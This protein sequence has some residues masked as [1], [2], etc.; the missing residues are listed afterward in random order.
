VEDD[1]KTRHLVPLA[2]LLL[3]AG[4]AKKDWPMYRQNVPRNGSQRHSS[5]LSN[6]S[7]VPSLAVR[8]TFTVPAAD[9]V[10]GMNP[11]FRA[12]PVVHKNRVYIGSGNGRMY[13][14]DAETGAVL[15][16]FPA[17]PAAPLRSQFTCNPSSQGIASSAVVAEIGE[18]DAVIFGAPD[19]SVGTNLGEGRLFALNAATGAEIWRSQVVAQLTGTTSGSTT[20]LHQQ[21]GYSSPIVYDR[22][23]YVGVADHCDNPIQKG[24]IVSVRLSDGTFDPA[25]TYCSTGTCGDSTRGGGVWSGV[26]AK[27][28]RLYATTGNANNGGLEPS[29][30]HGLSMVQLNAGTGAMGWKFQPVPYA[31]DWDPDWSAGPNVMSTSCGLLSASTMKDGWTH[32]VAAS[33]GVRRWTFPPATIPFSSGDGT[34]HGD[35]RFMRAGAAWG[36]VFITMTGG[37]TVSTNLFSAYRR[38]HALNVCASDAD[39]IRWIIDVPNASGGTYSLGVPTVTRGIVYIGTDQGHLVAIA[40]PSVQP[41][42]GMRCSNTDVTN[43]ACVAS[44]YSLVP[45]PAVLANVTLAG[46]M[47]YN[48]AAISKGRLFAATGAGNVYMLRP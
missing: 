40:D 4:C 12:S 44:G 25:F 21:I 33:T 17:P 30:N 37:L 16:K 15:W 48:E 36:D 47:V 13:A 27:A 9:T 39:R 5:D 29:P 1:M 41:A 34:V 6:P 26:A 46:S 19:P 11:G 20:Q 14:L 32:A 2:G 31:L 24:R 7:R 38:L 23:V 28:D 45:Q 10:S 18:V 43:A 42:A 8:W 35:T 22:R 3:L